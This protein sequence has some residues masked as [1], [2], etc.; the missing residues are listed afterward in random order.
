MSKFSSKFLIGLMIAA[1]IAVTAWVVTTIPDAPPKTDE[2]EEKRIMSYEGNVLTS[3][4]DGKI[5][6]K[7]SAEKMSVDV[8]TQ[9]AQMEGIEVI[10][11]SE[12][13][14]EMRLTAPKGMYFHKEK[15]FGVYDG[16]KATTTEGAELTSGKLYWLNH[17][18]GKLIAED[19]VEVKKDD[20]FASGDR[21]ESKNGFSNFKIIGHAHVVKSSTLQRRE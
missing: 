15:N 18:G 13:G 14:K 4:K 16:V 8:D 1:F 10:F 7:L 12:D 19:K 17:E 21:M 3:E 6:W 9:N 20:F 2:P 5:Q 11:Y